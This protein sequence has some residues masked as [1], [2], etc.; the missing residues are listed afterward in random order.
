VGLQ[1]VHE[2]IYRTSHPRAYLNA[3]IVNENDN[4]ERFIVGRQFLVIC[5]LFLINMCGSAIEGADIN[6]ITTTTQSQ[7]QS[8][9]HL[10]E[11]VNVV[12]LQSGVAMM[13]TT[14]VLGQLTSQVNAAICMLDFINNYFMLLTTYVSLAIEWSGLLHSVYLVQYAFSRLSRSDE[15][16][17]AGS[18]S[19][20][21][22]SSGASANSGSGIFSKIWF[23]S[24][25]IMSCTILCFS[26]A[27]TIQSL[28]LG[29]GGIFTKTSSAWAIVVFFTL[30]CIIGIMEGLQIAAF[31]LINLPEETI[32]QH[33]L[34][35]MN[36]KL[37]FE[38][39]HL[40][41][42]LIGRQIL[43]TA[44]MF[45]VARIT[46]LTSE[47]IND[48]NNEGEGEGDALQVFG[49]SGRLLPNGGLF[50][51][52]VLTILGSLAWRI[53]A[54]SF[55]IAFM[56]NPLVYVIV[57]IC[58][59]IEGS[60]IC[61][62]CW[63]LARVQKM[64]TGWQPDEVYLENAP[65]HGTEPMTRQEEDVDRCFGVLRYGYSLALLVFCVAVFMGSILADGGM[66]TA[67]NYN[68]PALGAFFLF[69]F[70]ICWL[71]FLEGGQGCLVGLQAVNK[72]AYSESHPRSLKCTRLAHEGD[73][74]ERYIVGRQFLVVLVL[75]L[76]NM[77]GSALVG[78]DPFGLPKWMNDIFLQGGVAMVVTTIV[79]GQ[80]TSQINAAICMLDFMNNYFVLLTTY[81]SL[82][83][84]WSGLLHTVYLVQYAFGKISGETL[85]SKE[86]P[87]SAMRNIF[88]WARV[89]VSTA[90]LCF[91][92]AVTFETILTGQGG[93]WGEDKATSAMIVF[94]VVMCI[95]GIMEGIQIAAFCLINLPEEELRQH[96]IAYMNCKLI[97]AGQHL[98]AFLIGRQIF[99]TALMF[100][101]AKI[102][103]IGEV[104]A[105]EDT[106]AGTIFGVSKGA[107]TFFN[108]GFL[109]AIVMTVIGS[110]AWRIVASSFPLAFMSNPLIYLIVRICLFLEGTG[111]CSSAWILARFAKPAIGYQPDEVYLDG[112]EE[113]GKEP[114]TLRDM[115]V[116]TTVTVVKY[117]Y[118]FA[119]L[120]FC[121]T[122]V[123]ATIFTEQTQL[124][125]AIHSVFAFVL[126]WFLIC[127]LA[128]MEG[129]QGCL[130][131]LQAVRS[132]VYAESHPCTFKN[133][134]LA[135]KGDNMDRFIVG[136]QFLVV[137]V[138]FLINMCGAPNAG[139]EVLGLPSSVTT[140]FLGNGVGM[141]I[142]TIIIGQLT[143]Q[144]NAAV[145]MLDFINNYFMLFTTYIS[146]AI[147]FSGLLHSVYLVQIGVSKITGEPIDSK[148]PPRTLAQ[149]IF[150]WA[151]VLMSTAILFFALAVTIESL[152]NEQSGI[153]EGIPIPVSIVI[154]FVFLCLVGLMD[155]MQIAAFA[156]INMSED[157]LSQYGVASANCKLMFSGQNLQAFLIGR[158]IF[159]AS[160]MFIVAKI[161]TISIENGEENI[162]G[163]PD[164]FQ[165]FLDTGLL[166]AVVLAI[167]GSLIWRIMASSFPLAF[168][169]NPLVY[170]IIRVCLIIE[171]TGICSAAWL[172]S[173]ILKPIAG[174]QPDEVYIDL[175]AE[176]EKDGGETKEL[177]TEP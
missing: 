171:G 174:Y 84:E 44:L 159:V 164:G 97:F 142:T 47:D 53:V 88:F 51:A 106:I 156:L 127:W 163:V 120:I 83:I 100:F 108:T 11:W 35:Y 64:M 168:M 55:P 161:A 117:L 166:G 62:S 121:V 5:I 17:G 132:S 75:F 12:F 3:R 112:A 20:S 175:F 82:A 141:M 73:N 61:S 169:S 22:A 54:S 122:V 56:S 27:V 172:L 85:E 30:M 93:V 57:R 46:A 136:R 10:P 143:S 103:T 86:P 6:M 154:F 95:V 176:E 113:Q 89:L 101:V 116:D 170:V 114:I 49:L 160:L 26:M 25:V 139:A 37:I 98:Q 78:A 96:T 41:P 91:A 24:R 4:M 65:K 102:T 19:G 162:F 2:R 149:G 177:M 31:A 39:Q 63:V 90:I 32:R 38:N 8:Q 13:I 69:W 147:E 110:L 129:G 133:T 144:I 76:I 134:A 42:F 104:E 158:Q 128:M 23:W 153:W 105:N 145:C 14:V 58:I 43:V 74:M 1:L 124:A 140:I 15:E 7:S 29:Q 34:A 165:A 52:F 126:F 118:S 59:L 109:A 87:R 146:L 36:C 48:I 115:N 92:L 77:I 125:S 45:F 119:L 9:F 111:I 99:V 137:L 71:A 155:G 94:L 173:L 67:V 50:G 107:Q 138:I 40:R 79:I 157:E 21:G 28:L 60:G 123:M 70:L 151:R 68:L 167:I 81:V 135:H 152:L 150:F 18:G 148:E 131:G 72:D 33:T 130:V 66:S 80:L 16:R